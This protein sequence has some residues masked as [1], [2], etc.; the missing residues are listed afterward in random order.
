LNTSQLSQ[1]SSAVASIVDLSIALQSLAETTDDIERLVH[2]DITCLYEDQ[3]QAHFLR[4][5]Y[6]A[7]FWDGQSYFD[8]QAIWNDAVVRSFEGAKLSTAHTH[9]FALVTLA[10]TNLRNI[11]L[12]LSGFGEHTTVVV[13]PSIL[14]HTLRHTAHALSLWMTIYGHL[15]TKKTELVRILHEDNFLYTKLL[16]YPNM[17][18]CAESPGIGIL[19][20]DY[21]L[22]NQHP[23][24]L[25]FA[26][27]LSFITG[28]LN[29][30][31]VWISIVSMLLFS[32]GQRYSFQTHCPSFIH[33]TI[34][35]FPPMLVAGWFFSRFCTA[36]VIIAVGVSLQVTGLVRFRCTNAHGALYFRVELNA[37]LLRVVAPIIDGDLSRDIVRC[38]HAVIFFAE[39]SFN[40]ALEIAAIYCS[41]NWILLVAADPTG[42]YR[43]GVRLRRLS[44]R[45]QQ[46]CNAESETSLIPNHT[47][48]QELKGVKLPENRFKFG[49]K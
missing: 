18:H 1:S 25:S 49:A 48:L 6:Y 41:I 26:L 37:G 32:K 15:C 12:A 31:S 7:R 34:Q 24:Y 38:G 39:P 44:D 45:L 30:L 3:H 13:G 47:D 36:M 20:F 4:F 35:T 17:P 21:D 29:T 23:I 11:E 5:T 28:I 27:V 9:I 2:S 46:P 22:W 8:P 14:I 43:A 33:R 10:L 40:S 42:L 16:R 19:V